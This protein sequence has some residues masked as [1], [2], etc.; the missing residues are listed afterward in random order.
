MA[1]W[2]S[3][4]LLYAIPSFSRLL[5]VAVIV[6]VNGKHRPSFVARFV[7]LLMQNVKTRFL[8]NDVR[9]NAI[10]TFYSLYRCL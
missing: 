7:M 5:S 2:M 10:N 3:S 4:R 8:L 1:V 6:Y 9:I